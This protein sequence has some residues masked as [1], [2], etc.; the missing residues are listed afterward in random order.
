MATQALAFVPSALHCCRDRGQV[1]LC[2][3]SY[4]SA[5]KVATQLLESTPALRV[6]L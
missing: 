4:G 6:L 3:P 2:Q 1:A 5:S